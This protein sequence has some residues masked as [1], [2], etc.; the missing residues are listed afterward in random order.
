MPITMIQASW[1]LAEWWP[2]VL[3]CV[4][5]AMVGWLL[6]LINKRQQKPFHSV[7]PPSATPWPDC[8]MLPAEQR[9]DK[10]LNQLKL[11]DPDALREE[12]L[13]AGLQCGPVT[14]T[15][16]FI[17][18]KKLARALLD[19][20]GVDSSQTF[21][22]PDESA[23]S[24][25]E[26][27]FGYSVGLNPP[28]EEPCLMG[29]D[30]VPIEKSVTVTQACSQVNSKEPSMYFAV[31]PVYEDTLARN[32]DKVYI[33]TDKKEALQAV[34]TMKGSRFK[35][36]PSRDDAEKFARG[37]CDYYP[38]PGKMSAPSSPVQHLPLLR[39]AASL[40]EVESLNKEKAN[41]FKSPRTQDLTAKLRKAVERGDLTAFSDLIWSNPRYLIGSGDNP[42]VVQEGCRYNVMHVA[43]KENQAAISQLL[44]DTLENPEFMHLM[45]P[46]DDEIMLQKRIKYIVDLYLNTPDKMGF[47]TPL[48][49]ACKFGN[50]D[51]VNVL[52]SHPDVIKKPRNKYNQTPEEVICE[53]S[54][55]KS[56]ELKARMKE[57]LQGQF[58]IPL[59][60][61]E[62]N[63]SSPVIGAPWSPEQPDFFSQS[64]Y[65]G[66]PKDPLLAVRAFA[67][68]MSPS[69]A[70]EFRKMW[71]TPPRDRAGFFHNVRK[72][73]PER[74]AERV[75]REL[76]HE[77][78]VP[79]LE[80]WDF[81]GGF[82]DLSSQEGLPKLEEY[83]SNKES[84]ERT[85][86]ESDHDLCNK[87]KTPSPAGKSKKSCNSV[88]VGAFLDDEED[89]SIEMKNRQNAALKR[90]HVLAPSETISVPECII[91]TRVHPSNIP[92]NIAKPSL[93]SPLSGERIPGDKRRPAF[94]GVLSPVSNLMA[95]FD[96]LSFSDDAQVEHETHR[97]EA[98]SFANE[99]T[100]SGNMHQAAISDN[101]NDALPGRFSTRTACVMSQVEQLLPDLS[102]H[103][104][105]SP[106]G[107]NAE[108]SH[109][110]MS[111][112]STVQNLAMK[113]PP[114]NQSSRNSFLLG[115]EP[116]KLD[117]DVLS[118][119]E[120]MEIDE[121][122][123][124]CIS[125]WRD[126]VR[127]YS[128]TDRQSWPSPAV[129][130][131]R[132]KSQMFSS[133]GSHGFS[134]PGRHS[135]IPG[136][137][138]KYVNSTDFSSPGRKSS[139]TASPFSDVRW[140]WF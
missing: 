42:T 15:T 89:T 100:V 125:R 71:K 127:T 79:W 13:K 92:H 102:L 47:D 21:I 117:S 69:K 19:Q 12:L 5:V 132:S 17:F 26:Q 65:S 1:L 124:P 10:L 56:A 31:C 106:P 98:S 128:S 121:Q 135:P 113:T 59:L 72:T 53:R 28:T 33:Y 43:S 44:L 25:H 36:F 18:E 80:Y 86:L 52:C 116:T 2:A 73:D 103:G 114:K 57:Y 27:E 61:A 41:S 20:Q 110:Y 109:L 29:E 96:K 6:R 120:H 54:K 122:K 50:A 107:D 94:E 39:D 63:S 136:S 138:G 8:Q 11:L 35:A 105:P 4:T 14:S 9:M 83:L 78:V 101:H 131:G 85:Q 115:K 108:L 24:S 82:A 134:T 139:M 64:R 81:L 137:P 48:H 34:K 16:R 77:L 23:A 140:I 95:E 112:G 104:D 133:P 68:P 55:S 76:A 88:S 60:R 118:A 90:N 91:D 58:Y 119:M 130:S 74:G 7:P 37:I 70:E 38:S 84:S 75:G 99:T 66:S 87:Y 111:S 93:H 22:P 126:S 46:D 129:L 40:A 51:V 49:F 97:K 62:D 3:A 32:M 30:F 45:Y 67:G 123:Y